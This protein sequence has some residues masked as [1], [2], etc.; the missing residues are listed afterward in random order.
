MFWEWLKLFE[1]TMTFAIVTPSFNK[2]RYLR[3]CLLSV[4]E[5]NHPGV[6]YLVLDN[7]SEDGSA[8]IL[9]EI[10]AENPGRLSVIIESDGGQAEAIN[11][12]F[13]ILA[14]DIMGWLNADDAYLPNTL[15]KVQR[16]FDEHPE[17][18]LVY[19]QTRIL[20]GNLRLVGT[21]HSQPPNRNI[22]ESYDFVPQPSAFWRRRVWD[23]LGPLDVNLNWGF[24][25]DYFVRV[26]QLFRVAFLPEVL[27][28]M[29]FDGQTKTA[30]GGMAK[31]RELAFIGKR[32]GGWRN[33]TF[34]YCQYVL[35]LNWLA[36]P[37]LSRRRT[38]AMTRN[39]VEKLQ[40]Y[41]MTMLSRV[42]RLQVMS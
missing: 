36:R 13:T 41:M 42:F 5:Q 28:E 15:T 12:G 40:A 18:D 27:S 9:Q 25:W 14:G 3:R 38:E 1:I 11:R 24:D 23:A 34:L 16:F 39:L 37:M 26:F 6:N 7:C 22:L 17:V 29:V 2:G 30:T 35:L 8:E 19:G 20:D 32:Y 4:V 33:P 31:T 10:V 21:H